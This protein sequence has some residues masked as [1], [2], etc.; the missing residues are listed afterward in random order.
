MRNS[1]TILEKDM[2]F[3]F[4]KNILGSFLKQRERK[5]HKTKVLF[6]L[7]VCNM[8]EKLVNKECQIDRIGLK[9]L[10]DSLENLESEK[11]S[12]DF[13]RPALFHRYIFDQLKIFFKD[14]NLL[15]VPCKRGATCFNIVNINGWGPFL[16][17]G[18]LCLI[19]KIEEISKKIDEII[20]FFSI[21]EIFS[22]LE[23]FERE[24]EDG[25]VELLSNFHDDMEKKKKQYF[26]NL[27]SKKVCEI[28]EK[29]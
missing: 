29:K 1:E 9:N 22:R 23:G 14:R 26:G 6:D 3:L 4:A 24:W 16:Y 7:F 28:G 12:V 15:E 20:K 27:W 18:D 10:S 2:V 19:H 5:I 11:Y 21:S 13:P 8:R 17:D 25:S